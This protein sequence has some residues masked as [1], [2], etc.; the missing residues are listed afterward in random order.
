MS[1]TGLNIPFQRSFVNLSQAFGHQHGELIAHHLFAS[2]AEYLLSSAV[3]EQYFAIFVDHDDGIRGGLGDNA[4]AF[5][6]FLQRFLSAL[7]FDELADLVA[8]G[9][10]R[11]EQVSV[12]RKDAIAEELDD[13]E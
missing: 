13:T 9:G 4:I 8:H 2:V 12:R 11:L 3:D 1:S 10:H 6:A 7:A 5:F